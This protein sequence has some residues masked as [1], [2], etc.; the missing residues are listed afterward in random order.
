V[1]SARDPREITIPIGSSSVR[2]SR[3]SVME[4]LLVGWAL[5]RPRS[6]LDFG[7]ISPVCRSANDDRRPKHRENGS[8]ARPPVIHTLLVSSAKRRVGDLPSSTTGAKV[9]GNAQRIAYQ[10]LKKK[11]ASAISAGCIGKTHDFGDTAYQ[12]MTLRCPPSERGMWSRQRSQA[13]PRPTNRGTA[14]SAHRW[15]ELPD[16]RRSSR[17]GARPRPALPP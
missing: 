10:W 2:L 7:G 12:I 15:R 9:L 14:T 4:T 17:R 5:L 6:F 11:T 16:Q 1:L 3:I 8:R 13:P